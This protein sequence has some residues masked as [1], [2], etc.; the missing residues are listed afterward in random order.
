M[1]SDAGKLLLGQ[2]DKA[3][4]LVARF[5]ACFIDVRHPEFIEHSVETLVGQRLFGLALGYEDLNDHDELRN[6]PVMAVLAGKLAARRKEC[7]PVA[8]K[9]T[10]NRLEK[11]LRGGVGRYHRIGYDQ[12]ALFVELFLDAHARPPKRIILDLDATR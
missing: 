1:T 4:G 2:A 3:I 7:V 6:D 5:A 9:S 11:A 10:L 8:G 12:E